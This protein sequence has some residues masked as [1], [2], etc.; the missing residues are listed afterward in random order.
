MLA[1]GDVAVRVAELDPHA[2]SER[3]D[4]RFD[5]ASVERG[6]LEGEAD[7]ELRA[8]RASVAGREIAVDAV[9]DKVVFG[10]DVDGLGNLDRAV[11]LNLNV[12]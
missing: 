12:A 11:L 3:L 9:V 1:D 10:A 7:V 8:V 2:V 4:R 6:A 5:R